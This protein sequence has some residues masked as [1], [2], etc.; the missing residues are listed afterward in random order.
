MAFSG[1]CR[2]KRKS[3]GNYEIYNPE[4]V[5]ASAM[6]FS[7]EKGIV[8]NTTIRNSPAASARYV[9]T[10]TLKQCL[11]YL[12]WQRHEISMREVQQAATFSRFC[13]AVSRH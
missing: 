5:V 13:Q 10:S 4:S 12:L 1:L 3:V 9:Q 7:E 11:R 2:R 8:M 6:L